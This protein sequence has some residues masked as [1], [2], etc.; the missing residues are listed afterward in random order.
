MEKG[1]NSPPTPSELISV[2]N[3]SEKNNPA[4]IHYQR[5]LVRPKLNFGRVFFLV[6]LVFLGV[7]A[8]SVVCYLITEILWLSIVVGL[9]VLFLV[10]IVFFKNIFIWFIKAYQRLAP[11]KVRN[12]CRFEPSCSQYMILAIEK[13]G[14]IKGVRKGLKRWKSCKPPNGG[15]DYP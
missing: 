15:Y 11:E 1:F 9:I 14:V 2:Y 8:I 6:C 3:E 5:K 10:I 13:Y 12:R 7:L 4:S